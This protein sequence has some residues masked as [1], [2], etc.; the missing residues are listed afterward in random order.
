MLIGQE[1]Q[2]SQIREVPSNDTLEDLVRGSAHI[3]VVKD[4]GERLVFKEF[5]NRGCKS[6][7]IICD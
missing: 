5:D 7:S 1:A 6:K 3:V 2:M 4:I